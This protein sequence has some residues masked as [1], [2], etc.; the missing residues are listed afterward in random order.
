M[1]LRFAVIA[2]VTLSAL[3][4]LIPSNVFAGTIDSAFKYGWG[5]NFG[6][7]NFAPTDSGSTYHGL[8][9][10]NSLV[11]GYAWS[12][13]YGWINFSPTNGGV[14]NNCSGQLG[15]YAWSTELG[16]I[17]MTGVTINSSGKFTGVGGDASSAGGRITF[18]CD[19]C[20]VR[21][22][23]RHCTVATCGNGVV[24][25]GEACD[26][27]TLNN[28]DCPQ[29]C[30]NSCTVNSCGVGNPPTCSNGAS[31][32]PTC[33]PP[34]EPTCSNGASDYPT[35]TQPG[36]PPI[37][38]PPDNPPVDQTSDGSIGSNSGG[39]GIGTT[40]SESVSVVTDFVSDFVSE[41]VESI[42]QIP[43]VAAATKV[44]EVVVNKA[45][46]VIDNSEVE[47]TNETVA[48]PLIATVAVANVVTSGLGLSQV[49]L[50]LRLVFSQPFLLYKRRKQKQ[51]GVV[52]NA[53]TKQPLD[54]AAVRL[55]NAETGSISQTQVT[56]AQGRY[57]ISG[58]PGLYRIEVQKNG[59][60]GT[61]E[62]LKNFS[63]DRAYA[64]LYHGEN[65]K[66][67]DEKRELNYSIPIDPELEKKTTAKLLAEYTRV[68]IQRS[69]SII[70]ILATIVSLV[71]SPKAFIVSLLIVHLV[72]YLLIH[73]LSQKK[74]RDT[75]GIITDSARHKAVG[76]AVVRVF[77][78]A[79]HK[80]VAMAVTDRK[81]RYAILV[82]PS[83]YYI[84]VEK[85]G[86]TLYESGVLDFSSEKT[87][88]M[89]GLLTE[90]VLLQPDSN[91]QDTKTPPDESQFFEKMN[92]E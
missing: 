12:K 83:T 42:A 10:T 60:T 58:E 49:L 6:W 84:T 80:L 8:T 28:G 91:S 14:T 78:S 92:K 24:E 64:N 89:G 13:T 81:G 9:I 72:V 65:F 18:D 79:Y 74:R 4:F 82:G 86:Y 21:T 23:W 77:D 34:V 68:A 67:Q 88:G 38:Q 63:E 73:R 27:G 53:Y 59:F 56:D 62:Y 71:I 30:S 19:N 25:S 55:I 70:G 3:Y 11:T 36:Q 43:A 33:T 44:V 15:G 22:D 76:R 54:L 45:K 17:P 47:K 66:V 31:D 41:T 85:K 51:W 90:N 29:A 39:G 48:A 16:W 57:F 69:V 87:G 35:C 32:Y 61:S 2:A 7:I 50:Y 52:Y 20:D 5:E 26:A 75:V 37:D 1:R 46:I 40:I